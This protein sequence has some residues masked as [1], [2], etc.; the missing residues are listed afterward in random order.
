MELVMNE[1]RYQKPVSVTETVLLTPQ[2]A[3]S[4]L[5]HSEEA[6]FKNRNTHHTRIDLL[7]N[8]IRSGN[9]M[10]NNDAIC[11]DV[12]GVLING[13]HRCKA[14][15]EAD[16]PIWV[17]FKR[18]MERETFHAMDTGKKRSVSDIL[19]SRMI[20]NATSV[21]R[22]SR[23]Q[24]LYRKYGIACF[25]STAEDLVSNK[26]VLKVFEENPEIEES[27]RYIYS[28]T[29]LTR[30]MPPGFLGFTHYHLSKSHYPEFID[31]FFDG[32][33]TGDGL[34]VDSPIKLLLNRLLDD[35]IG[36]GGRQL[37]KSSKVGLF[38]KAWNYYFDG[39]PIKQLRFS[40]NNKEKIPDFK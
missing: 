29:R 5:Y 19:Q 22:A 2:M 10:D 33:N 30:L 14:V 38:C 7:A 20:K 9:W 27:C 3:Q 40:E 37:N 28:R 21:A 8:E 1:S 12:S 25:Q 36:I 13:Y 15:I 35:I 18:G 34:T 26:D 16:E 17:T 4:L 11:T 23:L 6:G 31:P 39:K 32:L 24:Y